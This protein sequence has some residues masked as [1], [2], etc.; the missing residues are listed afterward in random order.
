MNTLVIVTGPT[1]VGK[2]GAAIQIA[3]TFGC[4][5]INADSRQVY[6]DIPIA[7]ALPT[8][9]Q[10]AAVPH[11]LMAFLPLEQTYSAW[12]FEHDALALLPRLWQ[13]GNGFAV[14]VG[15]SMMYV[16]ALRFGIDPMPDIRPDIRQAVL[17]QI[18]SEGLDN[19]LEELRR[20][21]P[22]YHA[23]VDRANPRRVAHA[24]EICRQ[25]G[26][27]YTSLRTGTARQRPF[28]I[29]TLAL[30]LP[31]DV[32]FDRINCRVLQMI[33]LGLED[34]ARRVYPMRQLNALN[35][36]GLKEMF[37]H[38]DGRLSRDEAIARI[39]KNTRVYA[40]KQLTWLR[41]DNTLHYATPDQALPLLKT[42]I[43]EDA[44]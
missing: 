35:T 34:E 19:L 8:A 28:R 18:E 33:D 30:N 13:R 23:I 37:A 24:I 42:L 9:G 14:V 31:R 27:T 6:A 43:G 3:Q 41:R 16:D 1:A 5:I 36:V 10:R 38:F 39:Q 17:D 15:G 32:L 4:E 2:T 29:I 26:S 11:H 20:R 25:T 44:P 22:E 12:Q 40:K 7:T 21:D